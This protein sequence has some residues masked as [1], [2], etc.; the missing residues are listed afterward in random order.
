ME[1]ETFQINR[2]LIIN[3]KEETYDAGVGANGSGV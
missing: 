3:K 2:L 1:H